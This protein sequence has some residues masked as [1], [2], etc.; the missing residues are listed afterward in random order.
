M[1]N[2]ICFATIA[3]ACSV[4]VMLFGFGADAPA[5][6][7]IAQMVHDRE[8]GSDYFAKVKMLLIDKRGG[9][10]LRAFETATKK[11]G[12]LIKS[13]IR[14]YRAGR[15]R[16]DCVSNMGKRKPRRRPVS[17]SSLPEKGSQNR[18]HPRKKADSSIP[19]IHTRTCRNAESTKTGI[20]CRMKRL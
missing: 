3:L 5:G 1:K 10:E 15:Y 8:T 14:F 9:K 16:G 13:S 17:I 4:F 18:R 7:D 20:D 11:F 19:I 2:Q 6:R 12:G